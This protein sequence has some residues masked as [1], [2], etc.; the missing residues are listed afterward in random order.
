M[1]DHCP[2][3]DDDEMKAFEALS[4]YHLR[5]PRAVNPRVVRILRLDRLTNA[6]IA[7]VRAECFNLGIKFTKADRIAR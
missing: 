1:P 2:P 7:E 4:R 3:M 6:Q 5:F